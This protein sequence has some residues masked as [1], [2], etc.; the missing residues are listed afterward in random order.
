MQ[1][2]VGYL[3]YLVFAETTKLA[4]AHFSEIDL[5]TKEGMII[6]FVAN[7]PSASQATIAREAGMKPPILVKLLD[8]LTEKGLLQREPS[9]TDRRRHHLRLTE[10]GE[11][12]RE[13]IYASHMAGNS[14]LFEAAEFSAEETEAL[15]NLLGKLTKPIQH[16]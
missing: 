9:A 16:R 7:N 14:E 6:E 12:L 10:V 15:L 13:Q 1:D 11:Q 2:V 4:M 8:D 5:N 3:S